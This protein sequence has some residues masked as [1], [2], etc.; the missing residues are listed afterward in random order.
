M[1]FPR[2]NLVVCQSSAGPPG[3]LRI[4]AAAAAAAAT[5]LEKRARERERQI[6]WERA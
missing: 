2:D 4:A 1:H 6:E 3:K 5:A